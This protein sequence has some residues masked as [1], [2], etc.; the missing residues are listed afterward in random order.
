MNTLKSFK[1]GADL[2]VLARGNGFYYAIRRFVGDAIDAHRRRVTV[3]HTAEELSQLPD[4]LQQDINW[5][6][7]MKHENN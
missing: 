6:A 2:T 7:L 3:R 1:T 4:Y 5:P